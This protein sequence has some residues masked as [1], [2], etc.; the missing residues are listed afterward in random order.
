VDAAMEADA[1]LW[2]Q[3]DVTQL[4]EAATRNL[5]R[6]ARRKRLFACACCRLLGPRLDDARYPAAL[7]AAERYADGLVS[8]GALVRRRDALLELHSEL[9]HRYGMGNAVFTCQAVIDACER[10]RNPGWRY[11]AAEVIGIFEREDGPGGESERAMVA[12]LTRVFHDIFRNPYRPV[13]SFD[14]AWRTPTAVALAGQMYESRDFGAMPILA[15][16]LQDAGCDNEDVLGHC[17]GPGPHVRG[18]WV[19]DLV[20]GKA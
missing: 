8:Y 4:C 16:A 1:E 20:L 2:S 11:A 17:R 9:F 14:S 19:V 6:Q 10:I 3:L 18:C 5:P 7:N 13:V 15:D 12:L